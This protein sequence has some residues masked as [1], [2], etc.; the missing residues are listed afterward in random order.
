MY[1]M[2]ESFVYNNVATE[3]HF[4]LGLN[5]TQVFIREN[6]AF[7]AYGHQNGGQTSIT[8][9]ANYHAY[10]LREHRKYK[11]SCHSSIVLS[12]ENKEG[13]SPRQTPAWDL[14][15]QF[16]RQRRLQLTFIAS[17]STISNSTQRADCQLMHVPRRIIPDT[18]F[19]RMMTSPASNRPA[20]ALNN[21]IYRLRH[22]RIIG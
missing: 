11:T 16:G 18:T 7:A 5:T 14:V 17:N 19:R 12:E 2:L 6:V 8:N 20:A 9:D 22:Q 15:I 1:W 3:A 4:R 21:E 13:I 10:R